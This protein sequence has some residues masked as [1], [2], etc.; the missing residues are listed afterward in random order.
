MAIPS[1]QS[2]SDL[3]VA[4]I[5]MHF[6]AGNLLPFLPSLSLYPLKQGEMGMHTLT[7]LYGFP[8]AFL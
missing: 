2:P 1:V 4:I 5:L 7:S 8:F 3:S 6:G